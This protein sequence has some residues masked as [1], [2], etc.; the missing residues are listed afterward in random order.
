MTQDIGTTEE[1][2]DGWRIEL[3]E[4]G[5]TPEGPP[6]PRW[7]KPVARVL[8]FSFL[9]GVVLLMADQGAIASYLPGIVLCGS[10][11]GLIAIIVVRAMSVKWSRAG[12]VKVAARCVDHEFRLCHSKAATRAAR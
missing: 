7:M 10:M 3:V 11:F 6:R 9:V 5:A 12:W 4:T 1:L 8:V 2:A